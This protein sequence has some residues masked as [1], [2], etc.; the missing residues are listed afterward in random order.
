LEAKKMKI[1]HVDL[2]DERSI[3]AAED[4]KLALE[5]GG[6]LL[7]GQR[8]GFNTA[9]FWYEKGMTFRLVAISSN[10]NSFGLNQFVFISREGKSVAGLAY[11][12]TAKHKVGDEIFLSPS[13]LEKSLAVY[14]YETPEVLPAPSSDILEEVF[15]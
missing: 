8:V 14:G 2:N 13:Q 10:T 9:S 12:P 3:K 1:I 7:A 15:G 6:Y 4:R 5:D 11:L